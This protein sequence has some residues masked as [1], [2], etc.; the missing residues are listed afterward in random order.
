MLRSRQ[1]MEPEPTPSSSPHRETV[2][3]TSD[4]IKGCRLVRKGEAL[5]RSDAM[6][7]ERPDLF[8]VRYPLTE[9]VRPNGS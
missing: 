9:E 1:K 7:A 4:V 2:W 8:E 3:A 5:P 6:V